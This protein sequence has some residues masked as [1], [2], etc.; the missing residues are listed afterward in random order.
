ML[1]HDK[2]V[3]TTCS[4]SVPLLYCL[5]PY[6][7]CIYQNCRIFVC[8]RQAHYENCF[9]IAGTKEAASISV[10][11]SIDF[12]LFMAVYKS[13][14]ITNYLSVVQKSFY[15]NIGFGCG[16]CEGD[17]WP[18]PAKN[19][20]YHYWQNPPRASTQTLNSTP[21]YTVQVPSMTGT[22]T[23]VELVLPEL[24]HSIC[25]SQG[26]FRNHEC[27]IVEMCVILRIMDI[28]LMNILQSWTRSS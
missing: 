2:C 18:K 4:P 20:V 1:S 9:V 25:S 7:V 6:T 10:I 5:P 17:Y 22:Q 27:L 21:Q 11:Y 8:V 23:V 13:M 15:T 24:Y 19:L 28:G 14:T 16:G 3:S 26:S 12:L